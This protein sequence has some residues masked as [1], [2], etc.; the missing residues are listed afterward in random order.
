MKYPKLKEIPTSRELVDVFGGYNHNLRIGSGEFYDMKNLSS[1]HYPVL[2]TRPKRGVYKTPS[3]P[4]GLIAKEELCYVDGKDFVIGDT[5]V[6]MGLDDSPKTLIS[7]GAYVIIMPDK[8]YINTVPMNDGG[9]ENGEIEASCGILYDDSGNPNVTYQLCHENGKTF[10]VF[11]GNSEPS[12]KTRMWVDTSESPYVL[13]RYSEPHAMWIPVSPTYVRINA[14]G[15]GKKFEVGDW[16]NMRGIDIESL[17]ELNN[18]STMIYAKGE[19]FIVVRGIIGSTASQTKN[20]S[21]FRKVPKM[22]FITECGNRLWGCR[23]GLDNDGNFVNEI[24]ASKLGDFK[25]WTC[26][27]GV[28]TDS[29]AAS[30]GTNGPF[31]GA[32]THL[33]YPLFFKEN[34]LHKIYGDY[35]ANFQI[36]TMVCRGV[37]SG[38]FKSLATVNEV[39]YYKATSGICAYDG[40]QPVEVSS[41]FGEAIYKNAVAGSLGN[42]YYVSMEDGTGGH[43]L[44]V[45][46]AKRGTWHREDDTQ[47]V[48]FASH[49]SDLYYIDYADN[50]IKAVRGTGITDTKPI[51]WHAITGIIG[52]DSP[53]KKYLSRIDVRMSLAVGSRVSFWAEYDSSEEWEFLFA[54]EG[55]KLGSFS[56]PIRP[57]RCDHLRLKLA[58]SGEAKVYS[59]CKTSE[60]GSDL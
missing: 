25:N 18:S 49:Q 11:V 30:V 31:T 53:D 26:F 46:D 45:Y 24:Y 37:Q 10:A 9:Y 52:T 39:L 51:E 4:Q 38:C 22:D 43:H 14:E 15:I 32:T 54:T 44:F 29:Y 3:N 2:S 34:C 1:D 5:R 60:Q 47:A 27:S 21:I 12:L 50:R 41:V 42:K 55:T 36:Q 28:S 33:G 13:K 17:S 35:P 48:S 8:K 56:I 58:G 20:L 7:M 59:I 57:K 23:Y 16:V 6:N 19:N 40:S